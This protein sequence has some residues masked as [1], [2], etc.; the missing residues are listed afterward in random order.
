MLALSVRDWPSVMEIWLW[1]DFTSLS[2]FS[3]IEKDGFFSDVGDITLFGDLIGEVTRSFSDGV[4]DLGVG[5]FGVGDFGVGDFG[6]IGD[7][8]L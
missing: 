2:S 6:E 8:T 7:L 1:E 4:G 5:D 3:P